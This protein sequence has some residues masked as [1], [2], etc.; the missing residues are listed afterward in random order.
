MARL[1]RSIAPIEN[2]GLIDQGVA[3]EMAALARYLVAPLSA[4][5]SHVVTHAYEGGHPDHDSVAFAVHAACALI[6][7]SGGA[8][9]RIV[10]APLYNAPTGEFIPQV[11]LPHA[12]AGPDFCM[13]LSP[14]EQEL[15]R[16]MYACHVSQARLAEDFGVTHESFRIAPRHHFCAPP[17]PGPLCYE[18]FVWLFNG[19]RWRNLAWKAMRELDLHEVLA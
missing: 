4:G 7:R 13:Q 16:A 1:G 12:D 19:R 9:P 17:H 11:F 10:E 3:P 15:K 14:E 18:A 6:A 8:P 2:L 5:F